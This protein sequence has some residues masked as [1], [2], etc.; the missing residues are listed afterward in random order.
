MAIVYHLTGYDLG[1]RDQHPL[2]ANDFACCER[3]LNSI[4]K[5]RNKLP[6][7]AEVSPAWA[8]LVA[9]WPELAKAYYKARLKPSLQ[10]R[11]DEIL[12]SV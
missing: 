5:L 10:S 2:D 4:P 3:L 6:L 1:Y 11:I 7:M 8:A 12:A 9:R